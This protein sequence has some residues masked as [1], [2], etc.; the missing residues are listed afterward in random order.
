MLRTTAEQK[1]FEL[2]RLFPF[3]KRRFVLFLAVG[4]SGLLVQ[5]VALGWLHNTLRLSFFVAQTAAILVA[6]LSNFSLNN[7]ITFRARRLR[8]AAWF[9]GLLSF[10]LACSLGALLNLLS[11]QFAF[12]LGAQWM[13]AGL[14]GAMV[15]SGFN[16]ISTDRLTW[17]T[18]RAKP[19]PPF[20]PRR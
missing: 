11:A 13:V 14:L 2:F 6:M 8:G 1:L 17:K 12:G 19:H 18:P 5:M 16:Y 7:V 3:L 20:P 15:G 4:L 10:C 9:G